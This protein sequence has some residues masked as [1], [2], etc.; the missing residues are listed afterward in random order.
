MDSQPNEC[1]SIDVVDRFTNHEFQ[2]T[3]HKDTH[4]AIQ[5]SGQ[6]HDA[7]HL[8]NLKQGEATSIL[9]KKLTKLLEGKPLD[10]RQLNNN[11][12]RK[13]T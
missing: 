8:E 1:L 11:N 3:Q 7:R 4:K 9:P 13:Q 10:I 5:D 6:A 2:E 12:L